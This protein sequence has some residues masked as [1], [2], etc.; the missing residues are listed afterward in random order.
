VIA[1]IDRYLDQFARAELRSLEL[2][3]DVVERH[4]ENARRTLFMSRSWS[5]SIRG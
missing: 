5:S 3:A 4:L 2:S 1:S